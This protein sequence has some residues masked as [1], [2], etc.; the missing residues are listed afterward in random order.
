MAFSSLVAVNFMK[1][2]ADA[3]DLMKKLLVFNPTKR[4]TIDQALSHPYV[5]QFYDVKSVHNLDTPRS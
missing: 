3:I 1:A 5:A 4:L 2:P